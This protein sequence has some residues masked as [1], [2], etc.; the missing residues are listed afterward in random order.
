MFTD[1]NICP[2]NNVTDHISEKYIFYT[3]KSKTKVDIFPI[4]GRIWSRIRSRI[5]I[6]FFTKRIRGS[7]SGS[8][9]KWNGS[10]TL[11]LSHPV[12]HKI[13]YYCSFST[14][15]F[16]QAF[17]C[18]RVTSSFFRSLLEYSSYLLQRVMKFHLP[19]INE[20]LLYMFEQFCCFSR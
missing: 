5:R 8:I 10:A 2:I 19:S 12:W 1:I 6:R 13:A 3:K 20:R 4:L 14:W 9:S 16:D 15:L 18:T 17:L 7:G 11:L